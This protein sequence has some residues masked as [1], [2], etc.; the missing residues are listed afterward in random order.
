MCLYQ[1][2]LGRNI[3]I[4]C[5]RSCRTWAANTDWEIGLRSSQSN[6]YA[7]IQ[8]V[9]R[10]AILNLP[11]Q[12]DLASR[13]YNNYYCSSLANQLRVMCAPR[14]YRFNEDRD[15]Q[16]HEINNQQPTSFIYSVHHLLSFIYHATSLRHNKLICLLHS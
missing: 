6:L 10:H 13:G 15:H 2:P 11:R 14:V 16:S 1:L 7:D 12:V 9:T 4:N 5:H 3:Y 8:E